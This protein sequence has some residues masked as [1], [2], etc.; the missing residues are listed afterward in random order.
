MPKKMKHW[1]GRET[2]MK[3]E[4]KTY[5]G[6]IVLERYPVGIYGGYD[7]RYV[8][9]PKE[10]QGI[11]QVPFFRNSYPRVISVREAGQSR[12]ILVLLKDHLEA[13]KY[14]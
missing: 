13:R 3:T 6:K 7:L 11:D 14:L 12:R 10:G 1:I 9:Q 4:D 8:F 2:T 5:Q